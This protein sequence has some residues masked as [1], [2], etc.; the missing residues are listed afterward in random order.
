MSEVGDIQHYYQ[1]EGCHHLALSLAKQTGLSLGIVWD[2][3]GDDFGQGIEPV[4]IH[5]VVT[6]GVHVLDSLG[7]CTVQELL[8]RYWDVETISFNSSVS[9]NEI[10]A[11]SG[12][13]RPLYELSGTEAHQAEQAIMQLDL[14][15][16]AATLK[17]NS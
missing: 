14:L 8:E 7:I 10:A 5:C 12:D 17:A 1:S 4:P 13:E 6:D 11:L 9:A 15:P 3:E 2:E 16:L